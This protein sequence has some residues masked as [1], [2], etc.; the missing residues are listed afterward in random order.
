MK[1]LYRLAIALL[2]ISSSAY[3]FEP[4]KVIDIRVEGLQRISAGTVFNYLPI[5]VGDTVDEDDS[6]VAMR[7][8]FKTGFFN[9]VFLERDGDVLVVN[10]RERAAISSIEVKGNINIETEPLLAGLKDIGLAEGRVFDRS[11]LEKVEQELRRQYFSQGKYAVRISTTVTP[12]ERNRVGIIVDISEGRAARIKQINIVGNRQF[13][14]DELLD[15]FTLSTPTFFSFYTKNDQ[16]SK[17][18]LSADLETLNSYYL[19]RGFLNFTVNSTQVSITPD[20][21]DIYITINITE[22]DQYRIREVTLSGDLVV[23]PEELFQL[24]RINSGDVFSR[25][26]VTR[27]VEKISAKLGDQG[28]AFANVNTVPELDD[29]TNEVSLAFFIDPGNRV[30]VRRVNVSGNVSTRDEVLRREMR[31]ME[32]GWFSAENV[33]RSR[34]RLQRLGFFED[35][36]VETP[37]V[38]GTPDQVDVNYAVTEAQSG[39][40]TAGLGFSQTSGLL[41]NASISQQN[42]LGSGNRINMSFNNSSVNTVY[43]FSYTNPYHTIDGISRGFGAY[44]RET[45]ASEA[46]LSDYTTD[47]FG[48]N[49]SFGLPVNE[50][51]TI[52]VSGEYEHLVLKDTTASPDEV[53]AFLT[54]QGD[55]FDSVRLT[56]SWSHDTRNRALFANRG[57]LIRISGETAIPGSGLEYYKLNY[58]QQQ[59]FPL[60]GKMTLSLNGELGYGDGFGPLDKLPFFE[61]FFAGGSRS[62]R[63]F[64]DNTLGPLDENSNPIGGSFRVIANANVYFPVPFAEESKSFRIG[65]FFDIGNVFDGVDNFDAGEL[66]YSVGLS[67]LWLSPLGPLSVSFGF[68]LNDESGDE[69][70]NFQFNIGSA[71]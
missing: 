49:I 42:F 58:R 22:G 64:Q 29:G 17:Q 53:F 60:T 25:K 8:L 46:N 69:I 7:A 14:D 11:L 45:D 23:K 10:V 41:F 43:S 37:P 50:F 19:D 66:R 39:S 51:D 35:V 54:A 55:T 26:H 5:K 38:P 67:G 65:V 32:S 62:V 15:K 34:T 24:V 28:Y 48:G 56:A 63:G 59:F 31:Q 4:F 1:L 3:A 47:V 16:Y 57:G 33:E 36:N 30:Y 61:N 21:R 52:R 71:F 6:A 44:F 9:D 12:L 2:F 27:A 20:K 70:Q 13:E 68:P 18:K 40:I